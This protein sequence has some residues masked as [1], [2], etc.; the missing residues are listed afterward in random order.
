VRTP[1]RPGSGDVPFVKVPAVQS[2]AVETVQGPGLTPPSVGSSAGRGDPVVLALLWADGGRVVAA[3][4][5]GR[6][7]EAEADAEHGGISRRIK[8]WL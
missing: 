7:G 3:T 2:E 6:V 5:D 1:S 8:A 4:W